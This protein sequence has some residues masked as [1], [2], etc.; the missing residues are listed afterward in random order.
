[1]VMGRKNKIYYILFFK[2]KVKT[3]FFVSI[4]FDKNEANHHY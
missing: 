4:Y 1:M 3:M 2:Q